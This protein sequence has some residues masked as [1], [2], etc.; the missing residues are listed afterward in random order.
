MVKS[1]KAVALL[2][3]VNHQRP[4]NLKDPNKNYQVTLQKAELCSAG[5]KK[6]ILRHWVCLRSHGFFV[7]VFSS[8]RV[9]LCSSYGRN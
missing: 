8:S 3:F 5:L 1:K 4:K 6:P 2:L 7:P 9:F